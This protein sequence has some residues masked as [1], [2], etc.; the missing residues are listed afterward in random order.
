MLF[1]LHC[2]V[3]CGCKV[4]DGIAPV[5]PHPQ[6]LMVAHALIFISFIHLRTCVREEGFS[7]MHSDDEFCGV[8]FLR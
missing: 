1:M 3:F 5:Q 6:L 8:G 4:R 7:L 2:L